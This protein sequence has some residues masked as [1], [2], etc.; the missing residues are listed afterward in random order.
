MQPSECL[1]RP[2]MREAGLDLAC[3]L[4]LQEAEKTQLRFNRRILHCCTSFPSPSFTIFYGPASR[5]KL[6]PFV[7]MH[8]W[9]WGSF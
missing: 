1:A 2:F 4:K 7:R 8:F 5:Q 6:E 9:S 3:S